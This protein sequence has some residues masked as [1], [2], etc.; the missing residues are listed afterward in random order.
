MSAS[1]GSN[2][3]PLAETYRN[4]PETALL[5]GSPSL[6]HGPHITPSKGGNGGVEGVVTEARLDSAGRVTTRL[7]HVPCHQGIIRDDGYY[8]SNSTPKGQGMLIFHV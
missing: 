6:K 8:S 4:S 2:V 5:S 1:D 3:I 7:T